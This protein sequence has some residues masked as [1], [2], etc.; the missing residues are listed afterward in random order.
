M[1]LIAIFYKM[2]NAYYLFKLYYNIL[3]INDNNL[4]L[5]LYYKTYYGINEEF[6]TQHLDGITVQLYS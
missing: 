4:Q 6:F 3:L 2:L 1:A 5:Y